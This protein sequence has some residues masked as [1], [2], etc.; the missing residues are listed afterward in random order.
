MNSGIKR[1]DIILTK[2]QY[3]RQIFQSSHF[4]PPDTHTWVR[5]FSFSEN[6]TFK[7]AY[8]MIPQSSAI[9]KGGTEIGHW[10][11]EKG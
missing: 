11:R 2:R 7:D 5:N 4:L 8:C 3:G 9:R 6:F 1:N 10:W